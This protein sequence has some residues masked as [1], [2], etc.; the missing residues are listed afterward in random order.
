MRK[1]GICRCFLLFGLASLWLAA[2]GGQTVMP[3]ETQQLLSAEQVPA[4]AT[5]TP[6]PSA[7]PT[8]TATPTPFPMAGGVFSG[9]AQAFLVSADLLAGVYTATDAGFESPNSRVIELR[10][11]GALYVLT[12]GRRG[13]WQLQFDRVSE[14][15]TPP[16]FINVVT[17]YESAEGPRLAL[18]REWHQDVWARI[19][20][21]EL[22]QL[23]NSEGLDTEHLVW[24]DAS[25]TVGLEIAYRNLYLFFTGP[26][27]GGDDYAF[28]AD[29]ARAHLDWIK[30]SQP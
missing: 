26:A 15:E 27:S 2:C 9:D 14:G 30:A 24:R 12:T 4:S 16:Y 21:G 8:V 17:I 3:T 25:G 10:P 11:D 23:P 19:D 6:Q 22:E 13:G 18:S 29:L 7:T 20:S 5:E 1:S 28:F